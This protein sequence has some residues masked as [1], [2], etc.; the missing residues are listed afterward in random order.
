MEPLKH[1]T[2]VIKADP[3]P[4]IVIDLEDPVTKNAFKFSSCN[5]ALLT[6]SGVRDELF[7]IDPASTDFLEWIQA[8][9]NFDP[10]EV[11]HFG[12]LTWIKFT[13]SQRWRIVSTTTPFQ[14]VINEGTPPSAVV[15]QDTVALPS[16]SP[17]SRGEMYVTILSLGHF[18]RST[19]LIHTIK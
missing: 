4:T 19:L 14:E 16:I 13:V 5:E 10:G 11:H 1:M 17:G 8:E 12:G 2:D 15:S 6:R 3:R 18:K 9:G 7:R